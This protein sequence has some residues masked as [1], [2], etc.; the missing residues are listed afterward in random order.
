MLV[1]MSSGAL[2]RKKSRFLAISSLR[3]S[4]IFAG[5]VI[6]FLP[7]QRVTS[8]ENSL[9]RCGVP[10]VTTRRTDGLGRK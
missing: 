5:S 1:L 10:S 9:P 4:S 3:P 6:S 7:S 8:L 2:G